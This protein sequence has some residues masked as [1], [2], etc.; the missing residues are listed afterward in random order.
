MAQVG[1]GECKAGMKVEVDGQPYVVISNEFVK[2][3]KGQAFNR[4]KIKNLMTARVIERVYKSGDKIDLADVEELS[5]RLLY[6]EADG[7]VFMDEATF[8]QTTIA[9]ELLEDIKGWLKED[10]VYEVVLYK[11]NPIS[12]VPPIFLDLVVI[13][14]SP[15]SRGDTVSGRVLKPAT[16]ETGMTIQVPIFINQGEKIRV[17]T[18]TGD[19]VSRV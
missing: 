7:V 8:E 13:E 5:M 15:G 16:L 2:P 14:T 17:D 11:G 19:Y 3:G 9:N 10:L 12:V 18:R 1:T 6:K 4:I